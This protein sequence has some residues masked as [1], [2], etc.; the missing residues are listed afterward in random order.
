VEGLKR[1]ADPRVRQEAAEALIALG[2]A[3]P[4]NDSAVRPVSARGPA[5][6]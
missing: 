6:R 5:M 2:G 3:A 1:D 4:R